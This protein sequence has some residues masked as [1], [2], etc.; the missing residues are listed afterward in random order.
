MF[1]LLKPER[2]TGEEVG[3]FP[4]DDLSEDVRTGLFFEFLKAQEERGYEGTFAG[5]AGSRTAAGAGAASLQRG[6]GGG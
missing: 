1:Q 2:M 4:A 6:D 5:G 3:A